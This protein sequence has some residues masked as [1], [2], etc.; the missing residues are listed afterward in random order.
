MAN[1]IHNTRFPVSSRASDTAFKGRIDN[2]G[3]G[4]ELAEGVAA[5]RQ[6]DHLAHQTDGDLAAGWHEY[7]RI[8]GLFDTKRAHISSDAFRPLSSDDANH[9]TLMQ[10]PERGLFQRAMSQLSPDH[11]TVI[12]LR[13]LEGMPFME[14]GDAMEKSPEEIRQLWI[15]AI[16]S[17]QERFRVL[18]LE[19]RS[20][21]SFNDR[22]PPS[23]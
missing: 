8:A 7:L 19:L 1:A 3:L 6:K 16:L 17:L 21:V 14:V 11:A 20:D 13:S 9:M 23:K 5:P 18:N 10:S 22:T 2:S 12:R 4:E 15:Q